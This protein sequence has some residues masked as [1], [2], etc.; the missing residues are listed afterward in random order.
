MPVEQKGILFRYFDKALCVVAAGVLVVAILYALRRSGAQDAGMFAER[1]ESALGRIDQLAKRPPPAARPTDYGQML[2]E[3]MGI[4]S[5]PAAPRDV[6]KL[7]APRVYPLVLLGTEQEC[8]L[9]FKEPLELESVKLAQLTEGPMPVVLIVHPVGMDQRKIKIRTTKHEGEVRLMAKAGNDDVVR[10]LCVDKTV[11]ARPVPPL[12]VQAAA[13]DA[14]FGI[15]VTF[16]ANPENEERKV[17][18]AEYAI[19]RQ[20]LQVPPVEFSEVGTVKAAKAAKA[21][22]AAKGGKGKEKDEERLSFVDSSGKADQTYLY[23]VVAYAA[24]GT[25]SEP[26]EAAEATSPPD[27]AFKI[28]SGSPT[29]VRFE[30]VRHQYGANYRDSFASALGEEIGGVVQRGAG[31]Y[32]L[33][34][35]C[36][37]LAYHSGVSR[38]RQKKIGGR[39][40]STTRYVNRVIY[41]DPAGEIRELWQDDVMSEHMWSGAR[42]VPEKAPVRKVGEKGRRAKAPTEREPGPKNTE[43]DRP[44][45]PYERMQER[46]DQPLPDR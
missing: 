3:G 11:S 40:I 44:L 38:V 16:R 43:R 46:Y 29:S 31:A 24:D 36:H 17:R 45:T 35:G 37:L 1:V 2:R 4:A 30:V 21:E 8:V 13:A 25:G 34:T 18:I 10:L 42:P 6:F 26:S 20:E 14:L 41:S 9:E 5:R 27:Y 32:E 19:M 39:I 33:L 22:K 15:R 7:S 28:K 23:A 12:A